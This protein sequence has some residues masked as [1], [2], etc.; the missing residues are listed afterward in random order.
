MQTRTSLPFLMLLSLAG[1]A[2]ADGPQLLFDRSQIAM[3][4]Q[5]IK[6]PVLASVW[7]RTLA[8]A[9]AFCNPKSPQY[10]DPQDPCPLPQ[11]RDRMEQRRHD[12]LLVHA[13]GRK[14]T[15][16]MEAIGFAYQLT[17]RKEL[18]RHG[19]ALLLATV[20]RY[21]ISHPIVAKGFAGGRGDIMRGL[22]FGYDL[23][24]ECLDEPQRQRVAAAA[25]DYLDRAVQEFNDPRLWWYKVHNYNGVNGGAAGCL[26]LAL[27]DVYPTRVDAWLATCVKTIERWLDAGFDR[28]GAYAEGVSYSGYGLSNTVLFADA[29]RRS[30]KGQLFD[31]PAFGRLATFY[32]LSLLP[33]EPVYDARN[34]SG[35]KGLGGMLLKL[36]EARQSGLYRWLWDQSGSET[37][38][39][40]IVWDNRVPALDPLSAGVP[41]AKHFPGRG[42]C[43]WRT[44]WTT[45]DVMFSIEAG[46]FYPITHNQ[47]DKG[48]FTLYGLGQRWATDCGYANEHGRE[49]RGQ[50]LGHSCVLVDG[51]GQA[52]SGAG[53]GTNGRIVSYANND[54]Y[55]YALA[56]CTEAYQ[57]NNRGMPGPGVEYARRHAL[58]VFPHQDAPAYAVVIDDVKKDDRAHQFTWQMMFAD[59]LVPTLGD[60]RALFEPQAV[61]GN[62]YVD[63]PAGS[64]PRG[65]APADRAG[66]CRLNFTVEQAGDYV[67]WGRVRAAAKESGKSNSFLVAVDRAAPIAWHT[68]AR[69]AWSWAA[70]RAGDQ[71]TPQRFTLAAGTHQLV[72][73]MRE[74]GAAV[75]CLQFT[76]DAELAPA[77]ATARRAPLFLEAEAGQL[78]APMRLVPAR[79]AE[80]RLVVRLRAAATPSLTVD[81]FRPV[82]YHAPAAFPRFRATVHS[83]NPRFIAVLL[84]LPA[85]VAEPDV[86]F[87]LNAGKHTVTI[88]WPQHTDTLVW[89]ERDNSFRLGE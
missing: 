51:Q 71:K 29:L 56:D 73:R 66:T 80:P 39:L 43:V 21:P 1:T 15:Q 75:D 49:G 46:P 89:T 44:G 42:L 47:A 82:D 55:G 41:R 9:E 76:R 70:V 54:R 26:A 62:A 27:R 10:A 83:V 31:H 20:E 65:A 28:E 50:T 48:H 14:L 53:L 40:R 87:A 45:R 30:G 24:A 38:L 12:A 32:A 6:A 63:T 61:S 16:Q 13:I 22:A 34:D 67:L 52:L 35:Y 79:R 18:G 4:R 60:G 23:L 58:F 64:T 3:L 77:L 68:P 37:S 33:G 59:G 36:A 5:R 19:A 7:A 8:D 78:A 72:L 85:A 2:A 17:G 88:R 86:Q 84:P 57:H 25:A 11:R 69:G 81:A 74:P